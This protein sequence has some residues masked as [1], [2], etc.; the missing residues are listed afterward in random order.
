MNTELIDSNLNFKLKKI[1][2]SYKEICQFGYLDESKFSAFIQ[3]LGFPIINVKK[4]RNLWEIGLLKADYIQ[5]TTPLSI[6]GLINIKNE[7]KDCFQYIDNRQSFPIDK[8]YGGIFTELGDYDKRINLYFHPFRIHIVNMLIKH[9]EYRVSPFQ[10]L[11]YLPGANKV[12]ESQNEYMENYT[13]EPRFHEYVNNINRVVSLVVACETYSYQFIFNK[14]KYSSFESI[15]SLENK[16]EDIISEIKGLLESLGI[17][18]IEEI[19]KKFCIEADTLEPNHKLHI[20][21]RFTN[22]NFRESLKGTVGCGMLYWAMAESLRH[23]CERV[24]EMKFLEE[25][26]LGFA[27]WMTDAK[28]E[29]YGSNR[30]LSANRTVKNEFLKKC[31]LNY[32]TTARCY[33]EGKT[34]YGALKSYFDASSGIEIKN[35]KGRIIEKGI[36]SFRESLE[37]DIHSQVFSFIL[38]DSDSNDIVRAIRSAA[39][40]DEFCGMFFLSNPD[41]EFGNFSIHELIEIAFG[42]LSKNETENVNYDDLR[43]RLLTVTSGKEF[44][45]VFKSA[46]LDNYVYKGAKWG[47]ALLTFALM[48]QK[49]SKSEDDKN[50]RPLIEIIEVLDR[51][52]IVGYNSTYDNYRVEPTTGRLLKRT[53][54]SI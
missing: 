19:R 33:V 40:N 46:N 9:F 25:D 15:E 2:F 47:E 26:E 7:K 1:S 29:I 4:I 32:S 45:K 41:F 18:R 21:L 20:L 12:V 34:E 11:T 38:V 44:M 52:R 23:V 49:Q 30:L 17:D 5:S 37:Q 42:L 39:E 14:L 16:R 27:M 51:S 53:E 36:V 48:N 13:K 6:D 50:Y 43:T 10:Y 22:S 28:K 24:F 35:L 8:G 54:S 31:G 3:R